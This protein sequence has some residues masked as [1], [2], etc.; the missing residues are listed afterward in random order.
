MPTF[1]GGPADL[2]G[3]Q[4][5]CPFAFSRDIPDRRAFFEIPSR[6]TVSVIVWLYL[7]T[8]PSVCGLYVDVKNSLVPIM[9]PSFLIS[10]PSI[11]DLHSLR[12]SSGGTNT[13]I[14]QENSVCTSIVMQSY[15]IRIDVMNQVNAF[16][17]TWIFKITR[18]NL[19][20]I[21]QAWLR[22]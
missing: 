21:L 14:H 17:M 9:S 19:P 1:L 7:A 10:C 3:E 5:V 12:S 22:R 8:L 2:S 20:A 4:L 13:Q 15:L 18:F 11:V 16:P 6:R